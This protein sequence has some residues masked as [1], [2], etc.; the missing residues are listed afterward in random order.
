MKS[1]VR[2]DFPN[3]IQSDIVEMDLHLGCVMRSNDHGKR[4]VAIMLQPA[5]TLLTEQKAG[6][7]LDDWD[8]VVDVVQSLVEQA[9]LAWG[10]QR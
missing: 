5:G 4:V 6:C 10:A 9:T 8:E 1:F 3:P 7:L 2:N